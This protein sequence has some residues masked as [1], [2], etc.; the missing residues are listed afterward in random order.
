MIDSSLVLTH[1]PLVVRLLP[2][3][4]LALSLSLSQPFLHILNIPDGF[5]SLFHWRNIYWMQAMCQALFLVL[6]ISWW[7]RLFSWTSVQSPL[8]P[9][10]VFPTLHLK[11]GRLF[12]WHLSSP[13]LWTCL[14]ASDMAHFPHVVLVVLPSFLGESVSEA[15]PHKS[16]HLLDVT[17]LIKPNYFHLF[18]NT[19]L[20][21]WN[22][23]LIKVTTRMVLSPHINNKK[24]NLR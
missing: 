12:L 8:N 22:Q 15:W 21:L 14:V 9:V 5:S 2:L 23:R 10:P 13:S 19:V 20:S 7:T 18:F 4:P 6:M 1:I 17:A 3:P 24:R 16:F 11:C